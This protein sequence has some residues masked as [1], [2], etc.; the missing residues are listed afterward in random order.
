MQIVFLGTGEAC[1]SHRANSSILI[2]DR[3]SLHLL[4]CGFTVPHLFYKICRDHDRLESL[5]LSH[6]HGD[7]FL[8]VPLLLL[9]MYQ[10]GR[11]KP[12][13]ILSGV[14]AEEK[15]TP[16]M[17]LAYPGLVTKL[18]FSLQYVEIAPD[19]RILHGGLAWQAA[20]CQHLPPAFGVRI[21]TRDKAIYY[22]GDG[23]PTS[24]S[25][26]LMRGT[27]LV[28]HEAFSLDEDLP[29]HS[30]IVE[31]LKLKRE[32][33][34]RTMALIHLDRNLRRE[35]ES[36]HAYLAKGSEFGVMFPEDGEC[37]TL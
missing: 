3:N 37:I 24:E 7:H 32:L 31:C 4:D 30:S 2:K 23:R 6:F 10:E 21:D 16:L 9:R 11:S 18:P 28:I 27:D 1:D 26:E 19:K 20:T 14:D 33:E 29:G 25:R 8:G 22:S 17:E 12:L 35:M 34:I 36:V 13:S 15:I 5:W